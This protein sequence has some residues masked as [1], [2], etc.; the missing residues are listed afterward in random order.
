MGHPNPGP[1]PEMPPPVGS[2]ERDRWK[3]E[4]GEDEAKRRM[5]EWQAWW[6][7][8]NDYI[9]DMITYEGKSIDE[10]PTP[11]DPSVNY[12]PI[13]EQGQAAYE[14][15]K[16]EEERLWKYG[17][18]RLVAGG[19]FT[20]DPD[21]NAY[22]SGGFGPTG[23]GEDFRDSAGRKISSPAS[24]SR[25]NLS[26]IGNVTQGI[27]G[28]SDRPQPENRP[29]LKLPSNNYYR[30][31]GSLFGAQSSPSKRRPVASNDPFSELRTGGVTGNN[32]PY[33]LP[34][35]MQSQRQYYIPGLSSSY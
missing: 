4:L 32:N 8:E 9:G 23:I 11:W 14:R 16:P 1:P 18:D 6:N 29:Y 17:L 31:Y 22:R 13:R 25:I 35:V 30:G 15:W 26:T 19:H 34:Y 12:K 33:N 21:L 24:S 20:W 7:A 27:G 5:K 3:D 10:I 2:E 28:F